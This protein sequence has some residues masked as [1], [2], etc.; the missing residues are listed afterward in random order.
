M[1]GG[2]CRS[3]SRF[4]A[5]CAKFALANAN[6]LGFAENIQKEGLPESVWVT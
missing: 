4:M 1:E 3:M 2:Y 6:S 5:D